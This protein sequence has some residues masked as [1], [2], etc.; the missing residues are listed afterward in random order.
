MK[1]K[2]IIIAAIVL[3]V[4]MTSCSDNNSSNNASEKQSSQIETKTTQIETNSEDESSD[5]KTKR[6]E[7]NELLYES[8]NIRITYLGTDISSDIVEVVFRFENLT[9][10]YKKVKLT[11]Y[12]TVTINGVN[13]YTDD[14]SELIAALNEN[15]TEVSGFYFE[16]EKLEKN[17]ISLE[18]LKDISFE[19]EIY[20]SELNEFL[21]FEDVTIEKT[22]KLN[23][24]VDDS[25]TTYV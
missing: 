22:G 10:E 9:N 21:S 7:V 3:C 2:I 4:C 14:I 15:S 24:K 18:E 23:V 25:T 8:S 6:K 19:F 16:V 5:N 1:R 20:K 11:P 12:Q 13:I 17:R